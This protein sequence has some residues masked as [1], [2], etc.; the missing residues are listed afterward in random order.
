MLPRPPLAP[1]TRTSSPTSRRAI[2]QSEPRRDTIDDGRGHSGQVSVGRYA[3]GHCRVCD[4]NL[5]I[6]ARPDTAPKVV[7]ERC[8]RLLWLESLNAR[9]YFAD[10]PADFNSGRQRLRQFQHSGAEQRVD[11]ADARIVDI[12]RQ[13][14]RVGS[15]SRSRR[16]AVFVDKAAEAIAPDHVR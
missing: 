14:A 15:E 5:R 1:R 13:L 10:A 12:D 9:A 11:E 2:V 4:C 7:Q 6:A 3:S 16:V 8:H